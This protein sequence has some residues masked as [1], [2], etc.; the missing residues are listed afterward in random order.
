MCCRPSV[1]THSSD[2]SVGQQSTYYTYISFQIINV[3]SLTDKGNRRVV[4]LFSYESSMGDAPLAFTVRCSVRCRNISQSQQPFDSLMRSG[5]LE[6]LYDPG[7]SVCPS[8]TP[9]V[10]YLSSARYCQDGKLS[11]CYS[12]R[13]LAPRCAADHRDILVWYI[14]LTYYMLLHHHPVPTSSFARCI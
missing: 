8:V 6:S 14:R 12:W 9:L 4:S 5:I 7:S 13:S 11:V 3:C 2:F 10:A 1:S